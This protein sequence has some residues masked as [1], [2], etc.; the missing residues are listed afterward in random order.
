LY[1]TADPKDIDTKTLRKVLQGNAKNAPTIML[2]TGKEWY[3]TIAPGDMALWV[4]GEVPAP[5]EKGSGARIQD[6][7][8]VSY[9]SVDSHVPYNAYELKAFVDAQSKEG[10]HM[11]LK[12]LYSSDAYKNMLS[13]AV[14]NNV[15]LAKRLKAE[16]K[17]DW[18]NFTDVILSTSEVPED[19]GKELMVVYNDMLPLNAMREPLAQS[20]LALATSETS[21]G[22]VKM[23][24]PSEGLMWIVDGESAEGN[25][26]WD[27]GTPI[28][29]V[30]NALWAF[31]TTQPR[32]PFKEQKSFRDRPFIMSEAAQSK[33]EDVITNVSSRFRAL[34]EYVPERFQSKWDHAQR[35]L[36]ARLLKT[37]LTSR[38]AIKLRT[39]K[40]I[41]GPAYDHVQSL[42]YKWTHTKPLVR[43]KGMKLGVDMVKT[44][45]VPAVMTAASSMKPSDSVLKVAD[46]L[47]NEVRVEIKLV[48]FKISEAALEKTLEFMEISEE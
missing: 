8:N 42:K 47:A 20:T 25:T 32:H 19:Y 26:V 36:D 23:L 30:D 24:S 11:T 3:P 45:V 46:V 41:V 48:G 44:K 13:N 39:V 7:M 15:E 34:P 33:F 16:D 4:K 2:K 10:H 38:D 21:A 9:L 40:G 17:A 37:P 6:D 12:E 27:S 28:Q 5:L 1:R 14:H 35:S 18:M 22:V 31:P 43:S 29:G